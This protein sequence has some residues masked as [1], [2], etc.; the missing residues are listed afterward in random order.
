MY[1]KLRKIFQ[2]QSKNITPLTIFKCNKMT[3]ALIFFIYYVPSEIQTKKQ[4]LIQNYMLA[5]CKVHKF[6][7]ENNSTVQEDKVVSICIFICSENDCG[8][9]QGSKL[10]INVQ[11]KLSRS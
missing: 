4:L 11:F 3:W 6:P 9:D 2:Y 7:K 8:R 1:L 10:I 5:I